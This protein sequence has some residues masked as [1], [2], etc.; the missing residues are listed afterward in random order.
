M[1]RN[2]KYHTHLRHTIPLWVSSEQ[3]NKHTTHFEHT[4]S[5]SKQFQ[6]TVGEH[7]SIRI[8][9]F[10]PKKC[11]NEFCEVVRRTTSRPFHHLSPQKCPYPSRHQR[12]GRTRH[13]L[14]PQS[15]K[16]ICSSCAPGFTFFGIN[17]APYNFFIQESRCSQALFA[18]NE[19][20]GLWKQHDQFKLGRSSA[21]IEG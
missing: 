3:T 12:S 10:I 19:L 14:A 21:I 4:S 16:R 1:N 6:N 11:N 2:Y 7:S 15:S 20:S 13:P 9:L 18:G 17:P 8:E 5:V